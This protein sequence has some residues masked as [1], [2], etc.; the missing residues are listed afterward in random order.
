MINTFYRPSLFHWRVVFLGKKLYQW[1]ENW[2]KYIVNSYQLETLT[3]NL[4]RRNVI[5]LLKTYNFQNKKEQSY[6]CNQHNHNDQVLVHN[7]QILSLYVYKLHCNVIIL[8]IL[9]IRHLQQWLAEFPS[10]SEEEP[11]S[12]GNSLPQLKVGSFL[13]PGLQRNTTKWVH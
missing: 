11:S 13:Y 8:F 4:W 2:I 7:I 12:N 3:C 5:K 10:H 1:I 9:K 6:Q